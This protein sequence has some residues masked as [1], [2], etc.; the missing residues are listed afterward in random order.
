MSQIKHPPIRMDG[1][2]KH[3]A[4]TSPMELKVIFCRDGV[5]M[6][7]GVRVGHWQSDWVRTARG[8]SRTFCFTPI[9]GAPDNGAGRRSTVR[10]YLAAAAVE[11]LKRITSN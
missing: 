7:D 9:D 5:V 11:T 8:A 3:L 2:A 4:K 6:A 1:H 10:K